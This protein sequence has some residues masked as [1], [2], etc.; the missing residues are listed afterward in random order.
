MTYISEVQSIISMVRCVGIQADIVLESELRVEKELH[1]DPTGN[2][3]WSKI[4]G[5]I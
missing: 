2:L 3:K 5:M 4:L 1:L